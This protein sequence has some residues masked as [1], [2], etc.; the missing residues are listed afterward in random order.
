MVLKMVSAG[1]FIVEMYIQVNPA[2]FTLDFV[3]A[4]KLS[5]FV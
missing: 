4:A 3:Q 2:I 1:N 5:Q